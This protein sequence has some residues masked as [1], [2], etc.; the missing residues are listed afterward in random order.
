MTTALEYKTN[1][2]QWFIIWHSDLTNGYRQQTDGKETTVVPVVRDGYGIV[3][4]PYFD[5]N[6]VRAGFSCDKWIWKFLAN[7]PIKILIWH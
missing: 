1:T 3:D 7:C 6:T 2:S 4:W 5:W